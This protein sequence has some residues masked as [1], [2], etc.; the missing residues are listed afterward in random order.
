MTYT[1]KERFQMISMKWRLKRPDATWG[2]NAKS[3]IRAKF[4]EARSQTIRLLRSPHKD[5][6]SP[7][8]G[9]YHYHHR[10]NPQILRQTS[11]NKLI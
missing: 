10:L 5:V 4:L 9:W 3:S 7:S 11:I 6:L 2:T 1:A 8:L